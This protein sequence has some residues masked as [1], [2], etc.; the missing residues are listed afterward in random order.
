MAAVPSGPIRPPLRP[1]GQS[2][3]S[4]VSRLEA[5]IQ[6]QATAENP[7]AGA[8]EALRQTLEAHFHEP[9]LEA[10]R[11]VYAS[12][13]A[14]RLPGQPVWPMLV[15]PPGSM[16]TEL[17]S[18]L[19]GLSDVYL[20]DQITPKTFISGQIEDPKKKS[21][22]PPG[23]LHRI[24]ANGILV[25]SDFSTILGINRNDRASILA[26]LRRIYDGR[27]RKE[28]GTADN[29]QWRDWQGRIT[30][31]VGATPD[32]DLHYGVFQS[33]GERFVMVRWPRPG[34][35]D[36]ALRAMNQDPAA[37]KR[38]LKAAVHCLF[39]SLPRINPQLPPGLQEKIAA[40]GEVVAR[41]RTQVPRDSRSKAILSVPQPESATRLPQQ[42]GQLTK[43]SALI[44]GRTVAG[45]EDYLIAR[46]AALDSIPAMRRRV[47]DT[48]IA[49][50]DISAAQLPSSTEHYATED[51]A[52]LG[53]LDGKA[54]SQLAVDHLQ[55][56]GLM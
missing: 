17:L 14:H 21:K 20:V 10:V 5:S 26:D 50:R 38:D 8:W 23:L 13:A 11:A 18:A 25:C 34:G 53:L 7:A 36:A 28:Y 47:L 40:L 27:L 55:K 44:G 46:R 16:K 49:G 1:D 19:D 43:G 35:T 42:L 39:K 52:V 9:D 24:G 12:V 2:A 4:E 45:E 3:D 32:V 22:A 51:L 30:F 29:Q 54:L 56:A 33:L 6:S 41:G 37:A 48:L 15:G 31:L